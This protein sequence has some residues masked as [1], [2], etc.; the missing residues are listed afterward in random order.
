[1][2]TLTPQ[3]EASEPN[4][5]PEDVK[6]VEPTLNEPEL[7]PP[8]QLKRRKPRTALV[9][10]KRMKE[11]RLKNLSQRV[12]NQ[13]KPLRATTF[14][15]SEK[16]IAREV[17]EPVAAVETENAPAAEEPAQSEEQAP[18]EEAVPAPAPEIQESEELS[19]C[20]DRGGCSCWSRLPQQSF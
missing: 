6:D 4:L 7:S 18:N 3:E 2:K 15:P 19:V 17:A 9:L 14:P 8:A 11:H 1:M 16:E 20:R 10:R 5:I 13:A 12:L